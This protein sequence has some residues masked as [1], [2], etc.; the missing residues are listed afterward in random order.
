MVWLSFLFAGCTLFP[1]DDY[2]YLPLHDDAALL[3]NYTYSSHTATSVVY[4]VE[5]S[6][7][8]WYN[9]DLIYFENDFDLV[10]DG[11]FEILNFANGDEDQTG[12][13]S[14]IVLIDQSG[15]YLEIDPFNN[16]SKAINKFLEDFVAPGEFLLGGF[17]DSGMV[18]APVEYASDNFSSSWVDAT[19]LFDL[20]ERTGG[21]S[22]LHDAMNNALDKLSTSLKPNKNMVVLLHASD[23]G[24]SASLADVITKANLNNVKIHVVVF[25]PQPL[26]SEVWSIA[27]QTDGMFA[28][29]KTDSD[30]VTVFDNLERLLNIYS[31]FN[32]LTIQFTPTAGSVVSGNEYENWIRLTDSY[33]GYEFNPV[34]VK[35]K[36]P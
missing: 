32:T 21:T 8:A 33:S 28:L 5:V 4:E 18:S 2:R 34:Y 12:N 35:V 15:S 9:A 3:R 30:I 11:T 1:A 29:C 13:S 22:S 10:G 16:R 36:I 31:A 24:S 6:A 7:L 25:G 20:A 17:S 19:F 14:T 27:E 23:G 26:P